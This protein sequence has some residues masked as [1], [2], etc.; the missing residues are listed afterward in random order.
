LTKGLVEH[1]MR[2]VGGGTDT[3]L[4]L[5]DLRELG[6]TGTE[7]EQTFASALKDNPAVVKFALTIR[8]VASRDQ[9][10]RYVRRNK[11]NARRLQASQKEE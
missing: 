11:D 8:D 4:A 5:I 3:H 9:V 7:A 6:V 2:A 10:D 1:G